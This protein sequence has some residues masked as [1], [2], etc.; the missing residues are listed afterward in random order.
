MSSIAS[1][2][3][4]LALLSIACGLA[5]HTPA[6]DALD[7]DPG[8]FETEIRTFEAWDRQNAFSRDAVLFV[9]SSSIRMWPTAESFPD[10]PVINRGFGGA[11]ISDVQFFAER[12]VVKY[13]PRVIVFYAGDNDIAAGKSSQQVFND[14]QSFV[15]LLHKRIPRARIVYL[16]IKPSLARWPLWPRMQ[17]ANAL[18]AEFAKADEQL[19]YADTATPMLGSDGQPRRELFLDD[20]LHLNDKG[21]TVWHQVLSPFLQTT[22]Q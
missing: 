1:R 9:G 14:F 18:I 17:A 20:G 15:Q 10:V 22:P 19:D 7:P 21:Y 2:S 8:R 12:I 16:P 4:L 5:A 13:N 6:T 11:H 3:Y